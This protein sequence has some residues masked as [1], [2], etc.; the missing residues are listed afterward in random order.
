M[1]IIDIYGKEQI[2]TDLPA[3]IKQ[4]KEFSEYNYS[5]GGPL[6]EYQEELRKYCI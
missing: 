5:N 6:S 4:T 3:A 1:K 2:V